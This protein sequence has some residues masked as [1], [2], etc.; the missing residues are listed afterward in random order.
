[1]K[2]IVFFA[3]FLLTVFVFTSA[4][5]FQNNSGNNIKVC[6][7][8]TCPTGHVYTCTLY[9]TTGNPVKDCSIG[10]SSKRCCTVDSIQYPATYYWRV[11]SDSLNCRGS[12]FLYTGG[13]MTISFPCTD[14]RVK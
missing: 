11:E 4:F 10:I 9:D 5:D 2:A 13:D 12:N 14:C 1:M 8:A 6:L 7:E 3:A